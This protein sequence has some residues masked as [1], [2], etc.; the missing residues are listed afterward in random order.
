MSY[1][2][3]P[4]FYNITFINDA[5]SHEGHDICYPIVTCGADVTCL[6]N[7]SSLLSSLIYQIHCQAVNSYQAVNSCQVLTSYIRKR[8]I[9][10]FN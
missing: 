10:S 3:G 1:V 7:E 5:H 6:W 2:D 8:L 9:I 4:N